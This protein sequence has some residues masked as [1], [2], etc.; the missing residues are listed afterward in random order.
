[1]LGFSAVMYATKEE[2]NG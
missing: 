1:M 2:R